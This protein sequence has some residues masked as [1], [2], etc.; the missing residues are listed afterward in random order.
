MYS[1]CGKVRRNAT[2]GKC[3]QNNKS[4]ETVDNSAIS[5]LFLWKWEKDSACAA[6]Q[7]GSVTKENL[8]APFSAGGKLRKQ[9]PFAFSPRS[10]GFVGTPDHATGTFSNTAP[11][12]ILSGNKK[13][14]APMGV[15]QRDL[16]KQVNF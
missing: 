15:R 10:Q 16:L 9:F 7:A 8:I 14:A 11:V 4:P 5:G 3:K 12:R 1:K 6:A 13:R 2:F